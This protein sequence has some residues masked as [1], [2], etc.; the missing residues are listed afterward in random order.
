MRCVT[1]KRTLPRRLLR[2]WLISIAAA[3]ALASCAVGPNFHQ[4]KPPDTSAYLHPTSDTAPV[5]AEKQDVQNVS[6]GAELAGEWWQLFHSPQLDE[7]VRTSITGSPTLRAANA[8]L[9]QAREE[10]TVARGA[11]L[12]SV[13]ATAGAQRSGAGAGAV[14][15][16]GTGTTGNLYSIGLS[17]SYSPDIFGGTRRAVEQQQA[18]A[19]FQRNELA[20]AYLTLTGSVVNEV[21]IIASTRLQIATAE[22]LIA[23]DRKNLALTQREFDVGVVPRSDVLTADSQL[24]ADLTQLPSLHK[25]LDQAYDALAVLS[26]RAPSEWQ[27]QPFDI[28]QFTLPRDIPLSLPARLVRQRP[29]VLAAETQL[30]AA[31]AAIGVAVAQEFPDI[32]LSGSITREALRAGDLFH[33]FNTLW[34]A[35]GSLTQPIFKGGA[36]RAQVRA[37]RD[38]FKASAA[39][40]QAVVL[41]ALGQVA[42]DLWA[43]QYDAQILTV[44][45]H[46]MDVALQA[47]KLQQQS[48]AVGTTTV[49]NLIAA[50]RAY[51]QA[52]LGY[53]S[54]RVQQFTDS[55]SLLTALGGGWWNDKLESAAR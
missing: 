23:S 41:E 5:Q 32:S 20:A 21:L 46:S 45:R 6:P 35:G 12:P 33:Q 36:L 44:D 50:E 9:A 13:S 42:D 29:D 28:D 26:G 22:E 31:S 4:P 25:Q 47:L 2:R 24:A 38:A 11:F 7:V 16:S 55:A 30:H 40:Y 53:V 17:T 54:A 10:V 1:N 18:L 48:Y 34:G 49:L 39:T 52:R 37:T 3:S 8:T 51:A 14:R 15:S 19:D 27:V 43:L